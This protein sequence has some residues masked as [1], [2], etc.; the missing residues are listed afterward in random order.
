MAFGVGLT[1]YYTEIDEDSGQFHC[2]HCGPNSEYDLHRIYRHYRF[3]LLFI[4]ISHSTELYSE[5]VNC[6]ACDKEYPITVLANLARKVDAALEDESQAEVGI[7]SN[8]GN[9][10]ELTEAAAREILR[11]RL[12]GKLHTD[13]V[14]RIAPPSRPGE[15]YNVGFDYA[16]AD[17]RDWIGE[18]RGIGILVDRRDTRWLTGRIIDYRDGVFCD[19]I[20]NSD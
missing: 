13:V 14:V 9:L 11:R 15:G 7:R 6:K 12:V 4:P 19:A 18:S 2:P 16:L 5:S 17:G 10:V 1:E 20:A 3:S 8:L